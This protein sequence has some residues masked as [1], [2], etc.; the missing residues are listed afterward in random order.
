MAAPSLT[1]RLLAE[2]ADYIL[3][4]GL[5]S[6]GGDAELSATKFADMSEYTAGG[7]STVL[8]INKVDWA[9]SNM[10]AKLLFDADTDDAGITLSGT[11]KY[12]FSAVH[13]IK[14]PRAAGY[15][16]DIMLA[17]YGVV[18]NAAEDTIGSVILEC[19]K[20]RY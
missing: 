8:T 17:T 4:E 18:I 6:S 7:A 12:D 1:V 14:N 15:T 10:N 5:I 20:L 2:S 19:K 11:G 3:L 16:G 9:L 13:G